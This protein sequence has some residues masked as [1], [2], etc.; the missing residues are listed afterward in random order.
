MACRAAW[1]ACVRWCVSPHAI[2]GAEGL[3]AALEA[4]TREDL[5]SG[6]P[7]L[8]AES[9]LFPTRRTAKTG[10]IIVLFGMEILLQCTSLGTD[11]YVPS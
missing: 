5:R 11:Y 8:L 3:V 1:R 10:I 2:E 7:D 9:A 4:Q 6:S